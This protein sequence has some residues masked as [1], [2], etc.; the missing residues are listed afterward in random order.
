MLHALAMWRITLR[1][2]P[3][4][5]SMQAE[6]MTLAMIERLATAI[7]DLGSIESV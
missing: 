7:V 3:L 2:S 4:L 6:A 5:P 1:H